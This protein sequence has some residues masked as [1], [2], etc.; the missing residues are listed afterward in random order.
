M[1]YMFTPSEPIQYCEFNYSEFLDY[2]IDKSDFRKLPFI[3]Q[4]KQYWAEKL[5]LEDDAVKEFIKQHPNTNPLLMRAKEFP[6]Q[7]KERN[8]MFLYLYRS[9]HGE[10]YYFHFDIEKVKYYVN[11]QEPPKLTLKSNEFHID[12]DTEFSDVNFQDQRLPFFAQM[13][14]I[15]KPYIVIDGNKRIMARINKGIRSFEGYEITPDIVMNSFFTGLEMWFYTLLYEI[16]LFS[17][18]M[19]EGK[20]SEEIKRYSNAFRK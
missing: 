8:E 5:E 16:K 9:E 7:F 12:S 10:D 6:E 20:S 3:N 18:L 4:W 14:T 17:I 13:F 2:A 19:Y 1:A 11:L 15:D